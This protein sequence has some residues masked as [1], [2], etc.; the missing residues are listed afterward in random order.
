MPPDSKSEVPQGYMWRECT[1]IGARFLMPESWFFKE[2]FAPGTFAYFITR[3]VIPNAPSQE[4]RFSGGIT[5]RTTG[6][7]SFY[8]T[9]LVIHALPNFSQ[10]RGIKPSKISKDSI[11][12]PT[13]PLISVGRY[14]FRQDGPLAI[15]RGFFRD[16]GM[17]FLG[18][19]HGPKHYYIEMVGNDRTGTLYTMIFETPSERWQDDEEIARRMIDNRVLNK[20]F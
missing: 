12:Q 16:D 15:Y 8:S 4:I 9:G 6:S 20:L 2:E 14:K 11:E 10:R 18:K 17:V 13:E 5:F 7:E 3:E 19:E 1:D